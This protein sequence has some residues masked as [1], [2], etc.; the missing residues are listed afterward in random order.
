MKSSTLMPALLALAR[1]AAI[2]EAAQPVV[3]PDAVLDDAIKD[4]LINYV[5][6]PVYGMPFDP[7]D[8]EPMSANPFKPYLEGAAADGGDAAVPEENENDPSIGAQAWAALELEVLTVPD[9]DD[10]GSN[11]PPGRGR[12]RRGPGEKNDDDEEEG[13]LERFDAMRAR[14][15]GEIAKG[16]T[17]GAVDAR[18]STPD[19]HQG[20]TK[21]K[22]C[23]AF[24][25]LAWKTGELQRPVYQ[26]QQEYVPWLVDNKGPYI[27]VLDGLRSIERVLWNIERAL[28]YTTI[29][30]PEEEHDI[31][32]C[33]YH[34]SG[35]EW[36]FTRPPPIRTVD[37]GTSPA[38]DAPEDPEAV[39]KR[40]FDIP[41]PKGPHPIK[42][43]QPGGDSG[44]GPWFHRFPSLKKLLRL[45]TSKAPV[46]EFAP[47][48][49]RRIHKVLVNLDRSVMGVTKSLM[50]TFQTQKAKDN[51][52]YDIGKGQGINR[53][54]L[55]AIEAYK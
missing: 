8:P 32:G 30:T 2:P 16:P 27:Y 42:G 48:A 3:V 7:D 36:Q 40:P 50:D 37:N 33:Y 22:L 55:Q 14:D 4:P 54:L 12:R 29:F 44:P 49:N 25:G 1:A 23:A 24:L 39:G 26:W 47:Y 41:R 35:L 34:F 10:D 31:M 45:I 5:G 13:L 18:P 9:A 51:I 11:R 6:G 53:N 15:L 17:G 43:P 28:Q 46:S 20:L 21:N 52:L 19:F 38:A